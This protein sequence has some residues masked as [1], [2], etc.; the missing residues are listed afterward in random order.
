[1]LK[2]PIKQQPDETTCG[3]TCLHA[4]YEYYG[5]KIPLEDV[6]RD[7]YQFSEGGTLGALL[8]IDALQRGYAAT[9]YSYD[10]CIFD[11]TWFSLK[12]GQLSDK[13]KEQM[14]YKKNGR[15]RVACE[16]Y[17][18]FL[19]LGGRLRFE[20]LRAGII[21]KYM[22]KGHPVIAGL[23]ATY[24]YQSAREYGEQS[25]YDDLRGEP[26]GHF[27]VLR[28]YDME[29]G[30]IDIADPIR[31]NPLGEG[32]FYKLKIARIINAILLGIVTYDANLIVITP[33]VSKT[34][35][36]AI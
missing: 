3:P 13:L 5:E 11:P 18:R 35:K 31:K 7:V 14:R 1:M 22:R 15:F 21:R 32:R 33:S 30:T 8:A 17:I 36:C 2:V 4:V 28:G 9:I 6:I 27:V 29:T 34:K 19:D 23:S 16:A 26:S 10:L 12:P 24:L 20:D 25:D